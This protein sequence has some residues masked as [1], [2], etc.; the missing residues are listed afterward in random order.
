[1]PPDFRIV[2]Q[3]TIVTFRPLCKAAQDHCNEHFPEDCPMFGGAYAVEHRYAPAIIEDL[4]ACGFE[5][6]C[7]SEFLQS[8]NDGD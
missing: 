2:D 3:G 8:L 1:M 7:T 5:L 6:R 4:T